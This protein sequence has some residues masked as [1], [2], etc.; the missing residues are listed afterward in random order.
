MFQTSHS[1]CPFTFCVIWGHGLYCAARRVRLDIFAPLRLCVSPTSPPPCNV[2]FHLRES[3]LPATLRS[4]G[5]RLFE[6][7]DH[8]SPTRRTSKIRHKGLRKRGTSL[9]TWPQ[10]RQLCKP[11]LT[12]FLSPT[13][14]ASSQ[15]WLAH[16]LKRPVFAPRSSGR[17]LCNATQS[18]HKVQMRHP[19]C[20]AC[21]KKGGSNSRARP[22]RGRVR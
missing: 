13:L 15:L 20:A 3:H 4:V 18:L 6:N 1:T 22:D 17:Q 21:M 14:N 12:V 19:C 16:P 10:L 2:G 8:S 7:V 5:A 11:C 9:W